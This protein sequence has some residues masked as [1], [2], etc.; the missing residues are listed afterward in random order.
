MT[1]MYAFK[2]GLYEQYYNLCNNSV[3][4][5]LFTDEDCHVF[6]VPRSDLLVLMDDDCVSLFGL[7][8]LCGY[9]GFSR[10]ESV[11]QQTLLM[12]LLAQNKL[13]LKHSL[14]S[15]INVLLCVIFV[16]KRHLLAG[17]A[18]NCSVM[19]FA[20]RKSILCLLRTQTDG[21][22]TSWF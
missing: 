13:Q 6:S 8:V 4:R 15:F 7:A 14:A 10:V 2:C 12:C 22:M 9:V 18:I 17:N 16:H 5:L 21:A 1:T 11:F 3:S 20:Y 19:V